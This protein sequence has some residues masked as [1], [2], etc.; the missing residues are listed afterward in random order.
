[1]LKI[2]KQLLTSLKKLKKLI[3]VTRGEKGAVAI[4]KE[5]IVECVAK[6]KFEN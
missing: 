4:N 3:I 2:L 6:G 1:M 5:E